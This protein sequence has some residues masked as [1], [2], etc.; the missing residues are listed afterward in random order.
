MLNFLKRKKNPIQT[1]KDKVAAARKR[2][3]AG[4]DMFRTAHTQV[5][6]AE[7]HL[8]AAISEYDS[9]LARLQAEKDEAKGELLST[10]QV[11]AKLED[12]IPGAKQ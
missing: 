9:E 11:K 4:L 7:E 6:E 2:R 10:L 12:F 3:T 1:T 8:N 5:C